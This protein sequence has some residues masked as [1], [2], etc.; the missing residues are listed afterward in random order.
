LP[1]SLSTSMRPRRARA[2]S[3]QISQPS[4]V[5]F[6][7]GL[8]VKNASKMWPLHLGRHPGAGVADAQLDSLSVRARPDFQAAAVGHRVDAFAIRFVSRCRTRPGSVRTAL[9]STSRL[10]WIRCRA[11]TPA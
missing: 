5:P 10:D 6:P 8:V 1:G 11:S 7:S 3:L 2:I 9:P 4:P